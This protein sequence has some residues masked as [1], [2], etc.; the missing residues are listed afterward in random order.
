VMDPALVFSLDSRSTA[1][2]P[3]WR[4][5]KSRHSREG[6]NPLCAGHAMAPRFRGGDDAC[7][8]HSFRWIEDPLPLEVTNQRGPFENTSSLTW[9]H[10]LAVKIRL[11]LPQTP[12]AG[13]TALSGRRRRDETP[14]R[15]S[16]PRRSFAASPPEFPVDIFHDWQRSASIL[17]MPRALE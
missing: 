5:R 13:R 11:E 9:R 15:E 14:R 4:C 12:P 8:C 16:Q 10:V 6:G 2:F 17:E 7:A 1:R 3:A